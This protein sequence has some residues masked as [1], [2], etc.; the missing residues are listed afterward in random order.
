MGGEG[1][2]GALQ[3]REK[4][5]VGDARKAGQSDA[6]NFAR[7]PVRELNGRRARRRAEQL[8]QRFRLVPIG[9]DGFAA[10]GIARDAEVGRVAKQPI[11]EAVT[12]F[13]VEGDGIG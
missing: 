5:G 7:S 3:S 4:R 1:D 2:V 9:E 6:G 13:G 11:K 12:M 10:L 8:R